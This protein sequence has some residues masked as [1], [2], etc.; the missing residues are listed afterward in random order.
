MREIRVEKLTLNVGAG[1]DQDK[2][3]KGIKLI[4]YITGTQPVKTV[5]NKRI[6]SWGLRPGLP[7]GCKLT[8]RNSSKEDL[9]KRFLESIDWKLRPGQFD[10]FGNIS[11][12]VHEYINIPGV[13]YNPDIGIMGFQISITLARP[14]LRISRRRL[15][16]GSVPM[17]QRVSKDEA[18]EFM[19]KHF[20]AEIVE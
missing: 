2:L 5:T 6:P 20:K 8:V 13:N 15:Q 1:K 14:G 3:E 12:G 16:K 9:I 10:N 4:E 7:I 19:K 18:I 11:F 17:K